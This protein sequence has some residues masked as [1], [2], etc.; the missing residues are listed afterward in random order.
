MFESAIKSEATRKTYDYYLRRFCNETKLSP[1]EVIEMGS[2][3]PKKLTEILISFIA[4]YKHKVDSGE[5]S[6]TTVQGFYKA[7][8]LLCVMNDVI[9]NWDKITR[10]LPAVSRGQDRAIDIQEIRELCRYADVRARALI[11]LMASSGVRVGAIPGMK[12]KHLKPRRDADSKL[13]AASLLVYAGDKE[14]YLTFMTPEAYEAIQ[15]YLAY[16]EE[17][18]EQIR[19]EAPLFRDKITKSPL[20]ANKP[21]QLERDGVRAIIH[22]LLRRSGIRKSGTGVKR[23]DFQAD[24]GFRKFFKTRT[25]QVMKP[26][27]VEMLMGH[28]TGVSG[29]YYRPR[30]AELL[31]DYRKAISALSIETI[32]EDIQSQKKE[33]EAMK[34]RL[35]D[36]EQS[37]AER[38]KQDMVQEM[39]SGGLW[40]EAGEYSKGIDVKDPDTRKR[41]LERKDDLDYT[42]L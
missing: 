35:D 9:L 12:I 42:K 4:Q 7:V 6:G 31:D 26:I 22:R 33:I 5:M 27:N 40:R 39:A 14:E 23:F 21:E 32:S 29:R 16:R 11:L 30:E 36:Y 38:I 20:N 8:K 10:I 15:K 25:E 37:L 18:G 1:E 2:S 41:L 24:H 28:S 13:V 3:N 19:D 17:Q 34:K